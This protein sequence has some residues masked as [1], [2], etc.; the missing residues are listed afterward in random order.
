[1]HFLWGLS[2]T[3]VR[4][5]VEGLAT[6]TQLVSTSNDHGAGLCETS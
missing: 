2:T 1:M 6:V 5:G 4:R 3:P